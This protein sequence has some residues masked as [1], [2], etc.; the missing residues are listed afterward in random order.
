MWKS[1]LSGFRPSWTES[2]AIWRS[3]CASRISSRQGAAP[4]SQVLLR[5]NIENEVSN[6]F[7]QDTYP[8]ALKQAQLKPLA[9]AELEDVRFED[10]G[11]LV[12]DAT[13]EVRPPFSVADYKGLEL[14][15][16]SGRDQRRTASAGTGT[17]SRPARSVET[18]E[19][20]RP[21]REKDF[22]VVDLTP[23]LEGKVFD[24]GKAVDYML[25]V[26]K[27]SLH[28]D[29]DE[30]LLGHKAGE[31][32]GFDLDYPDNS[33]TTEVA[34]KRVRMEVVI[35]EVKEKYSGPG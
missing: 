23:F 27:K 16:A 7:V 18:P 20:D 24:K 12:Y 2:T 29:F 25:E 30:H 19:S 1:Q 6:Q 8:E 4:D 14:H 31:V 9:E 33:P 35:K 22:A 11:T 32:L 28:P 26:G 13:V 10:S 15:Q 17:G 21:I 5:Q 34:G 3:K